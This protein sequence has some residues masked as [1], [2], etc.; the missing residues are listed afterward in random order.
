MRGKQYVKKGVWYIGGKKGKYRKKCQKG[1]ALPIGLI[2]L[3]AVPFLREIT[4]PIFK[5]MFG[6][7]R[8]RKRRRR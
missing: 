8:R 7:R 3:A 2:A 1:G 5:K 4:K 6:G